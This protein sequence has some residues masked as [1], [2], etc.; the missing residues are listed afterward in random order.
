MKILVVSDSHGNTDALLR[1]AAVTGPD[2]ILHLGDHCYDCDVLADNMP[3]IPVRCV[4]GNCDIGALELD[5]DEFVVE[6]KRIFMTHG[7][8]YG[9]KSSLDSLITTAM[10]KNAD[11]VLF[12]HTHRAYELEYEDMLILNPG[13]VGRNEKSYAVLTVENGTV[14]WEIE[15][16]D[17]WD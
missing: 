17:M 4:K 1:A 3:Q 13:S 15:Y 7:D 6:N 16:L 5:I 12:G 2:L 10:Y 14:D 9:V 8:L 11:I